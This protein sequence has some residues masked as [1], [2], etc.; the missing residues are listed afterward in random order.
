MKDII[1]G[2]QWNFEKVN[3]ILTDEEKEVIRGVRILVIEDEDKY[4]WLESKEDTY[5]VTMGHKAGREE[6]RSTEDVEDLVAHIK[7]LISFGRFYG[8]L[9][10]LLKS[11]IF[12]GESLTVH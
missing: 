10:C 5:S 8:R 1:E 4:I 3:E 11:I 6:G 2:R 7:Y 12:F 9:K